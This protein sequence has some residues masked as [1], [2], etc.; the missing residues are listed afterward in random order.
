MSS[1]VNLES[2]LK[3]EPSLPLIPVSETLPSWENIREHE[4]HKTLAV[5]VRV[6]DHDQCAKT[7]VLAMR[8]GSREW[9]ANSRI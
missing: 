8:R 4:L 6:N 7:N 2:S 5:L 9:P 3:P 1:R